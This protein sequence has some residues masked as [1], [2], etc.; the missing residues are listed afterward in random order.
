MEIE[1]Q[2]EHIAL[3][4]ITALRF[5]VYTAHIAILVIWVLSA[6]R[7]LSDL[8]RAAKRVKATHMAVLISAVF[9]YLQHSECSSQTVSDTQTTVQIKRPIHI[10]VICD[11]HKSKSIQRMCASSM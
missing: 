9:Q 11:T 8:G 1:N 7:S 5:T 10:T 4:D 3:W 2:T 6:Y